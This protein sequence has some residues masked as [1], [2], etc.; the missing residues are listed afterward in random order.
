MSQAAGWYGL[1][2]SPIT[3]RMSGPPKPPEAV[4]LLCDGC[5]SL[6]VKP[7]YPTQGH[8]VPRVP[9]RVVWERRL[10]TR[11]RQSAVPMLAYWGEPQSRH[12]GAAGDFPWADPGG[13]ALHIEGFALDGVRSWPRSL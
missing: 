8:H 12:S 6:P 9:K 7:L 3:G 4:F 10:R 13:R 5:S 11:R 2:V 1:A